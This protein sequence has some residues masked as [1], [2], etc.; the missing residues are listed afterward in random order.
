MRA[1]GRYGGN[2]SFAEAGLG[3]RRDA[4][5]QHGMAGRGVGIG[6]QGRG[7]D[8]SGMASG[9]VGARVLR[10]LE[11]ECFNIV[12]RHIFNSWLC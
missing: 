12:I 8:D 10:G 4:L 3:G 1:G 2:G 7:R 6:W 9:R 5:L 11:V